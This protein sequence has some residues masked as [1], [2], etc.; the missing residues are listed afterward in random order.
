M[1]LYQLTIQ[2]FCESRCYPTQ[3]DRSLRPDKLELESSDPECKK[4][5][6]HWKRIFNIYI[7]SINDPKTPV[8]K[9][10]YLIGLVSHSNFDLIES[11]ANFEAAIEIFD[12][13]FGKKINIIHARHL[14][15]SRKQK[16]GEG[17]QDFLTSLKSLS[18][19]CDFAAVTAI[20]HQEGYIR[21][22]FVSGLS[23]LSTKQKI[24]ESKDTELK[25]IFTLA[26]IYEEAKA[27]AMSFS[28][29]VNMAC[30]I[31]EVAPLA[32][33]SEAGQAS[34]A[35]N[36]RYSSKNSR[37]SW[38]GKERHPKYKCPARE[39]V[40]RICHIKGHWDSVCRS[41]SSSKPSSASASVYPVISSINSVPK[42][43]QRSSFVVGVNGRDCEAI[44]DCDSLWD[45]GAGENYIKPTAAEKY[46]LRVIPERGEVGMAS[47]D[48]QTATTGYVLVTLT[49]NGK[50]YYNMK[51]TLLDNACAD[52]ILGL[53]FLA[54]HKQ[55]IINF[56]GPEP[57]LV[58]TL[59][60]MKAE[61]PSLFANLT[62]DCHPVAAKSRR[63]STPDRLFIKSEVSRLLK[64]GIIEKSNSPWRS[65][66]YVTGGGNQKKRMVIDYSETINR[67]TLLDAYP[68]PRMDD[69]INE[70]AQYNVYSPID[71]RSAYHQ[72]ELN[73]VDRPFTA[74]EADGGLYQ[75]CRLPFGVTN[76]VSSFQREMDN[77]VA[78]NSLKG[79]FP[80]L[81][82]ITVCGK[83]QEE[84]D[85]NLADFLAAAKRKNLT[86]N[87]D[88]CE[89]S[90]KKL[91]LL[92]SVIEN[93]EIRPD[94]NRLTALLE[95]TP[96]TDNKSLKRI[97]G[98]FAHYSKWIQNFSEKVKPLVN[99]TA[100][101]LS[102]DQ[103]KSFEKLKREVA[104]SVVGAIK[105]G[106]PFTVE[107]D[108]SHSTLAATLN[109]SGR[110]VAF[111]SRSLHGS[112]LAHSS[113]EKEA[114]AVVEAIRFWRHL[115]TGRHFSL[116]TDQKSVSFMF[117]TK[118]KGKVKN[119]KIMRWRMELMCYHFDIV[120]RP[121]V[122]NI[123]ADTLSRPCASV[124]PNVPLSTSSIVGGIQIEKAPL[125]CAS[126][127]PS[128]DRLRELHVSLCHPGV[129]RMCH[130]VKCRNL[131]YS[132]EDIRKLNNSCK[133]CAEVKPRYF[134]PQPA[135]LIKATQPF[136]RL[137]VDFKGPLPSTDKNK[138]F[139]QVID[140][141]SRFPFIIPTAD[142]TA[143]T[144][145]KS[146]CSLFTMFG[147]SSYIH[148]DRGQN[149]IGKEVRQFLN[150]RGISCS[151]TTPYNPECNGQAEKSNHTIWRAVTL[152]LR[153]KNWPQ[154]RWQEVLP[155][156][157]HS[158]R[159][160]LCT[161]TNS[162][163]HE[164][165]FNFQR[166]S[167]TGSSLPTWLMS[168][169]P[170]LLRRFVRHSKQ[171]PLVDEVHLIEANPQYAFIRYQDG[172]ESTVSIKDLAPTGEVGGEP[173]VPTGFVDEPRSGDGSEQSV[174][175]NDQ[176]MEEPPVAPDI[177]QPEPETI[178][179]N[180]T[181]VP[182]PAPR[183]SMRVSKP[184]SRLIAET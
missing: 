155:D 13:H 64:E 52:I 148:S 165:L 78:E 33:D 37:C 69:L 157:V 29:P 103:V 41:S 93:G 28:S 17:L 59:G 72:H 58:A 108:A 181:Q 11:S 153:S 12:E 45:T 135:H 125:P 56:G 171:E 119:E 75:F 48:H 136:E 50:K 47:T 150:S 172:R 21:D 140:E 16:E 27:N 55:L 67:F 63:F 156:V 77:F 26:Q 147:M 167:G 151:R 107:T 162:T 84:H 42:S 110:P 117:D 43:L 85:K 83:T 44:W 128:S 111:F 179:V 82:N 112:E 138:Y 57:P 74:F 169:G 6:S 109:Q 104:D 49:V 9:L 178:V 163:P 71:L 40:C 96:P 10:D 180:P 34:A 90:T 133:E 114:Q 60:T 62:A 100:F 97:L 46:G 39:S 73:P 142:M 22:A 124:F 127:N 168:P 61:P 164:R 5:W 106:E 139:L 54:R 101:P 30:P 81:D 146:L 14:L 122:E 130:F 91:Y 137:N 32:S 36:H 134:K 145:I 183:R 141:Y 70:I 31:A 8:N 175:P 154:S 105:E 7:D 159:T 123:S 23:S 173:S 92:G 4:K 174:N 88:K 94:P 143:G 86:L 176:H 121:G 79:C 120:Y 25:D 68:L 161:A 89:F 66:P 1:L 102:S 184:P 129:T 132:V 158:V 38:C 118:H 19:D 113:V 76:G 116:I 99:A 115:L 3:M 152:A 144:I 166:K 126:V 182:S 18:K 131:P 53:D 80:Y 98:F 15:L 51:L 35:I 20:Q 65:Q 149:F 170:V 160:L 177:V 24:L 95:L 2:N 87:E